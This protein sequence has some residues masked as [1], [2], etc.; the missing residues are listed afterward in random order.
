MIIII[1]DHHHHRSPPPPPQLFTLILVGSGSGSG[2]GS[3]VDYRTPLLVNT[4]L[5]PGTLPYL[6]AGTSKPIRL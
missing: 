4:V 1:I 6:S 2:S 5:P 3:G